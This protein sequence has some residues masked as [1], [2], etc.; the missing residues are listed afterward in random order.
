MKTVFITGISRGIGLKLA[1]E[2]INGGYNVIGTVRNENDKQSVLELAPFAGKHLTVFVADVTNEQS[3]KAIADERH[4][5][6]IDI[7]INNAGVLGGDKQNAGNLDFDAWMN[8]LTVNTIAPMRVALALL[9]NV[10]AAGQGKIVTI[11]SIMGSLARERA[12][13]IAYRSSKAA[14]NKA[15][16]CLAVDLKSENVGVYLMHPGWV[17]TDMGGPEADISV[18]ESASGL[19]KTITN[20][21]MTDSGRFWQYDGEELDW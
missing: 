12:D 21:T 13:S 16:Q 6:P 11:S 17:R 9:N 8:T 5:T 2:F 4:D 7:L 3:V 1:E 14:V 15:M 19:Y 18:E 20:F 10:K